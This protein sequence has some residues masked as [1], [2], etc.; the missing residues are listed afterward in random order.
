MFQAFASSKKHVLVQSTRK[1]EEIHSKQTHRPGVS[2]DT[3]YWHA[4]VQLR[5]LTCRVREQKTRF[6]ITINLQRHRGQ[7]YN[8]SVLGQ[9]FLICCVALAG[10]SQ[11]S[12]LPQGLWP[13]IHSQRDE[14]L[15]FQAARELAD[16]ALSWYPVSF[17]SPS[18]LHYIIHHH[19]AHAGEG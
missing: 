1:F 14:G 19:V 18:G 3:L 13:P 10:A 16:P 9:I 6:V 12:V 7:K 15:V 8:C 11:D 17:R 4:A 5:L 2:R